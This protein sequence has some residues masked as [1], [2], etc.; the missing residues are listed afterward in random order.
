[1]F[2]GGLSSSIRVASLRMHDHPSSDYFIA[3]TTDHV[4]SIA[5]LYNANF[6]RGRER[7]LYAVNPHH[8]AVLSLVSGIQA[9]QFVQL[10]D[11]E[12]FDLG[13]LDAALI[14]WTAEGIWLPP[15]C[16]LWVSR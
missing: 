6:E 8:H 2:V 10:A 12:R 1:M 14:R 5:M 7:I 15:A 11:H 13:G 3:F 16:G 4:S 9:S